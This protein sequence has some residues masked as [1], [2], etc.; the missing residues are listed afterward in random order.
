MPGLWR[1]RLAS[2]LAGSG[3]TALLAFGVL[4]EDLG[5]Q[6]GSL[7][8]QVRHHIA[9]APHKCWRLHGSPCA[10]KDTYVEACRVIRRDRGWLHHRDRGPAACGE[11]NTQRAHPLDVLHRAGAHQPG[12]ELEPGAAPDPAGGGAGPGAA[13]EHLAVMRQ[14]RGS[15]DPAGDM[16]PTPQPLCC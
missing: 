6:F 15:R 3:V 13:V 9:A 10:R 4:R 16:T 12:V 1:T 14:R 8:E 2:F 7:E 5:R 11:R